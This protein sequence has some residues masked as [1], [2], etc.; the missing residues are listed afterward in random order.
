MT[1]RLREQEAATIRGAAILSGHAHAGARPRSRPEPTAAER[2]VAELLP[3]EAGPATA[4]RARDSV[5]FWFHTFCLNRAAE[6]YTPGVARDHRYRLAALPD[7]FA[8]Q[9]VLDVGTFDG[10]YAFLA[11]ARGAERVVAVDNEQYRLWVKARWGVELAGGEG[12]RA[13]SGLLDSQIEYRHLDAFDLEALHER[14]DVIYCWGILHR[15]KDP[16]GLLRI[17]RGRLADGGRV[18]LETYGVTSVD[19]GAPRAHAPGEVYRNDDH[20]Y[21]GFTAASL[22]ALAARA[23]YAAP[24]VLDTPVI[25]GH[26]RILATLDL[27]LDLDLDVSTRA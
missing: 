26:P 20:V 23:G 6:I 17:L 18:L 11:E 13:I 12:F 3:I 25:D 27:D 19:S 7:S 14:F 21:W 24:D 4:R 1:A 10:L 22:A 8:G 15:V 5:P 2:T 9:R 16:L